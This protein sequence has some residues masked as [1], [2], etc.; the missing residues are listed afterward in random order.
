MKLWIA[1]L[2]L[3]ATPLLGEKK[4]PDVFDKDG[5]NVTYLGAAECARMKKHSEDFQKDLDKDI[6]PRDIFRCH[7]HKDCDNPIRGWSLTFESGMEFDGSIDSY[8]G[9]FT[10]TKGIQKRYFWVMWKGGVEPKTGQSLDEFRVKQL[11]SPKESP[12]ETDE[13]RTGLWSADREVVYMPGKTPKDGFC[14]SRPLSWLPEGIFPM[15]MDTCRH[16]AGWIPQILNKEGKY[17]NG[18]P[19]DHGVLKPWKE[20]PPETPEGCPAPAVKPE[21]QGKGE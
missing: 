1:V 20:L 16:G 10:A 4:K 5:C 14:V 2:L 12:Y 11:N 3:A 7:D 13:M 15:T 6:W 18:P 19:D 8:D 9:I 21:P 17:V